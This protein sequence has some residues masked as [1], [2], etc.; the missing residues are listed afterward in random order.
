MKPILLALI[1]V[2]AIVTI[3]CMNLGNDQYYIKF[4]G[5]VEIKNIHIPPTI[6]LND[7]AR[8]LAVAQ[9]YNNC[10]SNLKFE[11]GKNDNFNYN[12]GAYGQYESYGT[13]EPVMVYADTTIL[14][15]PTAK[16]TY[17]FNVFKTADSTEIDTLRVL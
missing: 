2:I 1:S 4:T 11:L 9:A 5:S 17:I 14:F 10:W 15:K 8:I 3:S 16:G 7:T 6:N 13:C 12:V